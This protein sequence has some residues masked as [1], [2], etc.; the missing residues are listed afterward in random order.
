MYPLL[1]LKSLY[2]LK[3]LGRW[4]TMDIIKTITCELNLKENQVLNTVKLLD[5]GNTVPFI[6]RYRKEMTGE[7]DEI[8]IREIES[9]FNYLRNLENRKQEVIRLIDEQGKMTPKLAEE[10][11]KAK[12]LQEVEDLYRPFKPKRRTRASI[13][14]EKGLEPLAGIIIAQE[15]TEGEISDLALPFVDE[16][17]GVSSVEEAVQG[18]SDI[19]A[20]QV[21][22]NAQFRKIIREPTVNEGV[23][24]AKGEEGQNQN[25]KY[26][27]IIENS[28][29]AP[30]YRVLAINR[31]ERRNS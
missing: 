19:I 5:D 18:A 16:E 25:M 1:E 24:T 6:A 28:R 14:K 10:I 9:R 2:G 17:K 22:D 3:T 11:N 23:L 15:A 30:P 27:M 29:R 31:G 26:I 12:I 4:E 13:A 8:I 21:S 20:E 7:L